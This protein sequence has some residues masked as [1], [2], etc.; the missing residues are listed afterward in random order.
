MSHL[1]QA[2][3]A[4]L[5]MD[6]ICELNMMFHVVMIGCLTWVAVCELDLVSPQILSG[7]VTVLSVWTK[8]VDEDSDSLV[9]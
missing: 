3:D 9:K 8:T 5:E 1:F 6:S 2:K 7:I 4:I